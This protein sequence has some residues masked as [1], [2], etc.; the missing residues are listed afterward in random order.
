MDATRSRRQDVKQLRVAPASSAR[1]GGMPSNAIFEAVAGHFPTQVL[2]PFR[3]IFPFDFVQ[4]KVPDCR[5][6]HLDFVQAAQ[7][8]LLARLFDRRVRFKFH[9]E[10]VNCLEKC[11]RVNQFPVLVLPPQKIRHLQLCGRPTAATF[12]RRR[13]QVRATSRSSKCGR[14]FHCGGDGNRHGP[15]RRRFA[16]STSATCATGTEGQ[17][18]NRELSVRLAG[19]RPKRLSAARGGFGQLPLSR[20][21]SRARH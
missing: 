10:E 5:L 6:G 4:P 11:R 20:R 8:V 2:R 12:P 3:K 19:G 13:N 21:S 7:A 9:L 15:P 18:R 16:H 1:V 14:R 17:N